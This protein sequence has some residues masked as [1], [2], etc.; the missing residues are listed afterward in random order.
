MLDRAIW[1]IPEDLEDFSLDP[2]K[3]RKGSLHAKTYP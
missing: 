1:F 2:P 3:L